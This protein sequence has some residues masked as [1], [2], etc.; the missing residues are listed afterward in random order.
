MRQV[1]RYTPGMKLGVMLADSEGAWARG[2]DLD[3]SIKR[4][5]ALQQRLTAVD[6]AKDKLSIADVSAVEREQALC[7]RVALLEGLLQEFRNYRQT[8]PQKVADLRG[9]ADAALATNDQLET[10]KRNPTRFDYGSLDAAQRLA[11]CRGESVVP[12]KKGA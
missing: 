5:S 2:T 9:R 3:A 1:T 6:D 11:V 4:E 10:T 8:T 7:L 12:A